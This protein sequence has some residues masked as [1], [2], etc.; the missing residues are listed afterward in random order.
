[1][2]SKAIR[3]CLR[4]QA[5]RLQDKEKDNNQRRQEQENSHSK[6]TFISPPTID[7]RITYIQY[8]V[9]IGGGLSHA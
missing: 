8:S 6:N 3:S 4:H 2:A 1:M 9:A 5:L 7:I